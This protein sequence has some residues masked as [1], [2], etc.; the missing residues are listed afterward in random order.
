MGD[1]HLNTIPETKSEEVIKSSIEDLVPI[2]NESEG[3]LENMCDVPF[4][5]KNHFDAES[6]LIESLLTRDTSIVYSPKIDSLLKEFAGELVHIDPI[7]LGIDE[8]DSDPKDDINFIEQLSYDD[9]L[10]E[11]DSFEDINYVEASPPDS[12]LVSLEEVKDDIL[13]AKLLNIHLLIAMIESS[14][15]NPTPDCMLKSSSSSFLSYTDNSS[16]EFE[17]FSY[18]TE[19]TSSGSTTTHANNS[20]PQYDSFLFEIEPDQGELTSIVMNDIPDNSTNDPFMEEI[21]LFLAS[22]NS[23]PSG[24]ENVNYDSEGDIL[25]LEEL[26]RNDSLPLPEFK[27]FHFDLYDDLSSHRPPKK[28][29]DDGG[30]LTIKVVDDIS[31]NLTRQFYVHVLNVLPS[32]PTLYLSHRGFKIFQLVNNYESLMMI[33]GENIPHLDVLFLHLYL[34]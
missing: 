12:E 1:E 30:I 28:P 17:T 23:I 2:P 34:P 4:S 10:S 32:F 24:I 16:P 15:N 29:P 21:D 5:D 9:T 27:S 8:T 26:L 3:T 6:D 14:N 25:F 19:E 33:C 31:D 13:H 20:L 18:H 7:P 22:D 11:D